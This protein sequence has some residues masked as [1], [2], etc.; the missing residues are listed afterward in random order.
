MLYQSQRKGRAKRIPTL[1]PELPGPRAVVIFKYC[2]IS[3][4]TKII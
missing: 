3:L 1:G 2:M 4:D